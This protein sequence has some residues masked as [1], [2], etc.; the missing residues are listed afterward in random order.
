MPC[1]LQHPNLRPSPA[2][3]EKTVPTSFLYTDANAKTVHLAGDFNGWLDN[4]DGKVTGHKE[5]L[6]QN[7]GAGNWALTV[8][9][10][11]GKH[12]FKYVIDGGARWETN[13]RLPV[14]GDG[15]SIIDV[16]A[17]VPATVSPSSAGALFTYMDPAAKSVSVAGEFNQWNATANPMKKGEQDV[18]S[19]TIPLKPGK[20]LYKLMVDGAWKTDPLSLDG[21][22]DGY[23]GK[24]SV[25]IVAP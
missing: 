7:V 3:S 19:A 6:L 8:P 18:W 25:K 23:G 2:V 9:L 16:R 17:A 22:D 14:D 5:W 13:L 11:I 24:N 4:V 10:A 1:L 21:P 12:S 15:N 20:Y